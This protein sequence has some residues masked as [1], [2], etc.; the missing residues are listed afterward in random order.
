M[1]E[2]R[3]VWDKGFKNL[4]NNLRKLDEGWEYGFSIKKPRFAE[5][6]I[7]NGLELY[8]E[9]GVSLPQFGSEF[10][11]FAAIIRNMDGALTPVGDGNNIRDVESSMGLDLDAFISHSRFEGNSSRGEFSIANKDNAPVLVFDVK[12]VQKGKCFPIRSAIWLESLESARQARYGFAYVTPHM[13]FELMGVSTYRERDTTIRAEM[14]P[15]PETNTRTSDMVEGRTQVVYGVP[16]DKRD[17]VWRWLSAHEGKNEVSTVGILL[18]DNFVC[19]Q[20]NIGFF[21]SYKLHNVLLGPLNFYS[22]AV[23]IGGPCYHLDMYK[24]K[25]EETQK[26]PEGHEIP[27]PTKGDFMRDLEKASKPDRKSKSDRRSRKKRKK[28]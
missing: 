18:F 7:S 23:Q 26:T 22:S 5:R 27:I 1:S 28:G 4:L 10:C 17:T 24:K 11:D 13:T 19:F 15:V 12:I 6:Y 25:G 9:F 3:E 2:S 14:I 21:D 16:Y 8:L 20:F